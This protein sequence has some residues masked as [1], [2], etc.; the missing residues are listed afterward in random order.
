M[1]KT[2]FPTNWI[3]KAK[4]KDSKKN[5]IERIKKKEEMKK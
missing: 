3:R 4:L 5:A 1:E 2:M